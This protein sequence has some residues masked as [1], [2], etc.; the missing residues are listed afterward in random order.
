M[1]TADTF[2]T[3]RAP[4]PDQ[5][6]AWRQ[7]FRPMFDITPRTA[8][9]EGFAAENTV[10]KLGNL[11]VSR[12]AAPAVRVTR[13][14]T[15]IRR[16]PVDH[17]VLSYCQHGE[18]VIRTADR[19][20]QVHAGVPYLWSLGEPHECNRTATNR[21]QL[22]LSRDAFRDLAPLLDIARGSV[23]DTPLGR[24]LGD[25]MVA[26]E[27]QLPHLEVGDVPRL[28]AAVRALVAACL[29][30]SAERVANAANQIDFGRLERVRRAVRKHLRSPELGPPLLCRAVGMSRSNLY[31][32][33]EE[34]GGVSRY[35]QRQ[36]LLEARTTLCD[37]AN[38]RS[39]ADLADDLCFADSSTFGRA[40]R[41]AFGYSPSEARS[42]AAA[43]LTPPVLLPEG[44]PSNTTHFRSL[45]RGF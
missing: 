19:T 40:F 26:L 32:L 24:L 27:R 3:R 35:I 36:R 38:T 16:D 31:R 22:F 17:W 20:L 2:T 28:T 41:K 34:A 14:S 18:T 44:A 9:A 42:A 13:A 43:G 1:V 11:I 25:F 33:M 39:I 29:A 21:I 15:H 5:H 4:P 6:E 8:I 12:V 23:L 37:P 7:W 30:P 10:W 45:L